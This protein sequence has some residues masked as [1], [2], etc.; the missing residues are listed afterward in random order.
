MKQLWKRA[1]PLLLCL[2]TLVTLFPVQP[3]QAAEQPALKASD[4]YINLLKGWEGF[5]A[6]PYW[7]VN[8]Y[9][10]GYGTSCPSDQVDYYNQNP[11]SEETADAMMRA[12]LAGFERSVN[13]YA[14]KHGLNLTQN[15]FDALVS[16]TYN[17]GDS[18]TTSLNGYF[19]TALRYG[20]TGRLFM[21]GIGLYGMAGG[22]YI[23]MKRRMREAN[24]YLNGVYTNDYP[25]EFRWVFLDAA[26]G[27]VSYRVYSYDARHNSKLQVRFSY[28]PTGVTADGQ[29]F[30]YELDGW[31]TEN[32]VKV[33]TLDG[34]L[35][36]GATLYARWK[37]PSGQIVD[38]PPHEEPEETESG[39]PKDGM[40]NANSVNYRTGP[41]TSN[42]KVGKKNKG[43]KVT[44]VGTNEAGTWGQM[45]DGN[46]IKLTYVTY[47]E[48][49][50]VKAELLRLPDKLKYDSTSRPLELEGSIVRLT[51]GDGT[52]K[53]RTIAMK[54][55]KDDRKADS[56]KAV[57]TAT[58]DYAIVSFE[59][60]FDAAQQ[61]KITQQPQSV[62]VEMGQAGAVSVGASGAG[63]NYQWYY[64]RADMAA[65]E[66]SEQT[67]TEYTFVMT[68]VLEGCQ[69]YCVI[70]DQ[71]GSMVQT[72]TVSLGL[73]S[74][75]ATI[76][77]QPAS[78]TAKKNQKIAVSFTA[79]GEGLRYQWYYKDKKSSKFK[80]S[81]NKTNTYTTTMTSA[82]DGRQIY[83]VVTDKYGNK[84]QTE[85]VTISTPGA[86]SGSSLAITQ[87]PA[88]AAFRKNQK[89][90]VSFTASG[91]G[92]RYKWY[93][94]DR[95]GSKF[96][97]SSNK[98]NTYSTTM[99]SARNGRQIYCVV[100][101]KYGNKVQTE[102]VTISME[103]S[104]NP[105]TITQQPASATFRKN[106]KVAV[107]FAASGDGLRYKWYYKDRTGKKFKASSNKTNTYSTT[108]TSARNGRQIYCVVTDEYGNQV[109]TE[110]V[111]ISME[112]G[113]LSITQQPVS[114]VVRRNTTVSVSVA[115][116]GDGLR[117]RWYYKDKTGTKFKSSSKKTNT[118]KIKLTDARDG[119]QLYCIVTDEYGNQVQTETVTISMSDL[120]I[121]RQPKTVTAR[122][123]KTASVWMTAGGLG[124][125]YQWYYKRTDMSEFA[126]APATSSAYEFTMERALN[127]CK[128]YCVV[129][130]QNGNT[131][132]TK[133]VTIKLK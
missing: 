51:Y 83:C 34:S 110:T 113:K 7:D 119:R 89:V 95:T 103:T 5:R 40:V 100:T 75:R 116:S 94:K 79:S 44:I 85:T 82:R 131:A 67:G 117:Y 109:Q 12:S 36:R 45:S 127:K 63:L 99:T 76:T 104:G 8:H 108:M 86:S 129:T 23:L 26:G 15:Q 126:P 124:V 90:A 66:K 35:E 53:V 58:F 41:G 10:I 132:Q 56:T 105:L 25:D 61:L 62:G 106:Q 38:L 9:S 74:A 33:E 11:I 118:Y 54:D 112:I 60:E 57:V 77:Q 128:V 49:A 97:T 2:V 93:Y 120:R 55:V 3:V 125:S 87:Q 19:N 115:A 68:D 107:S 72:D 17:C 31:Y 6:T 73:N 29:P 20:D 111:T 32:G 80:T 78:A 121:T 71:F 30:I 22:K 48:K 101:D 43:D 114:A 123:G 64:K 102:T 91:D 21:Y 92:L 46:W 50:V 37:D 39:F 18:W 65:F 130:D 70:V 4:A 69:L 133:T 14:K 16:F 84:V 122:A 27:A 47:D 24:I 28:I 13:N 96:K 42:K 52:Q 88:S 98:T 1:L 81:S 59:V